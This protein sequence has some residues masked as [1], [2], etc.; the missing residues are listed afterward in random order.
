MPVTDAY[1]RYTWQNVLK[2]VAASGTVPQ[3]Q[4]STD[5]DVTIPSTTRTEIIDH[6]TDGPGVIMWLNLNPASTGSNYNLWLDVDGIEIVTNLDL[7]P[8][9]NNYVCGHIWDGVDSQ[10]SQT[11]DV[12]WFKT[13]FT[14]DAKKLNAGYSGSIQ[15]K[16]YSL[17]W[18]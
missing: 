9:G 16:W 12:I 6:S 4:D 2:M 10:P 3:I 1:T 5:E 14:V 11:Y 8:G 17:G 18:I 13:G 7:D 15:V